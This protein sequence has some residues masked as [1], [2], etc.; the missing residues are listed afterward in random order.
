MSWLRSVSTVTR[1]VTSS[2]TSPSH[3]FLKFIMRPTSPLD[4]TNSAARRENVTN[5]E[6]AFLVAIDREGA[7]LGTE[8]A[9][10]D[11]R[12]ENRIEDIFLIDGITH[13]RTER[14]HRGRVLRLQLTKAHV[15]KEYKGAGP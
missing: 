9:I 4:F 11:A 10:V 6:N 15:Y 5:G 12:R 2:N 14:G 13:L 3:E 1:A 7:V 8:E